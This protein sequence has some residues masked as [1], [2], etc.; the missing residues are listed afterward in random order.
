VRDANFEQVARA[1]GVVAIVF[2]RVGDRF[3]HNGMSGEMHHRLD[4]VFLE[5][6]PHQRTIA[7]IADHQR[8]I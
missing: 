3:R 5:Y 8:R 7:D 1:A 4:V 6:S 2:E